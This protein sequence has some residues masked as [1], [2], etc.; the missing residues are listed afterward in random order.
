[1]P[2]C[3]VDWT[4][5]AAWVQ[6]I[7]S[8]GAI[9]AAI[10]IGNRQ[11]RQSV[12]LVE[13]QHLQNVELVEHEQKR[14]REE[15]EREATEESR[16]LK[17]LVMTVIDPLMSHAETRLEALALHKGRTEPL[18]SEVMQHIHDTEAEAQATKRQLAELRDVFVGRPR[19]LLVHGHLIGALNSISN[20]CQQEKHLDSL[21]G[22]RKSQVAQAPFSG[23]HV[24][25]IA[26]QPFDTDAMVKAVNQ[27]HKVFKTVG[28]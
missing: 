26:E 16:D 15:S 1:M 3:V 22:Y 4:A 18:T 27:L 6:A 20:A 24:Q 19:H 11:H 17:E 21:R 9:A 8:I 13:K 10:W 23:P 25:Y 14:V 12:A 2:I 28:E 7:G 5:V